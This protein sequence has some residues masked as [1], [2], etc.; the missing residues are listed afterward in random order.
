MLEFRD[1]AAR[2]GCRVPA[3]YQK[4]EG[5]SMST[6]V[7]P[8]SEDVQNNFSEIE[9]MRLHKLLRERKEQR[10]RNGLAFYKP[11]PKQLLFH[12]APFRYRYARVGNRFGKSTMG[13]AEDV[14][15]LLGERTFLPQGTSGRTVSIPQRPVKGVLICSDFD[16][17]TEIF[18]NQMGDEAARG[19][20]FQLLPEDRVTHVMKNHSGNVCKISVKGLYGTSILYIETVQSYKANTMSVESSDWDF[21]HVDE[22]IPEGMWKAM[23]R[24]LVDRGGSAWFVCTMLSEPWINDFFIPNMREELNGD[25]PFED[26]QKWTLTGSMYDNNFLDPANIKEYEDSL[27]EDEKACRIHGIPM[28]MSGTIYKE[29]NLQKHVYRQT[30]HGW[31]AKNDPP[32]EYSIRISV[33][34][35]PRTPTAVVFAA[36]APTGEVFFYDELFMAGTI[37]EISVQIKLRLHNRN[38]IY[39]LCDPLGFIESPIDG[40]SMCD[41]FAEH[42]IM[43]EKAP[44]DPQ[45]GILQVKECLKTEGL[46]HFSSDCRRMLY[47]FDHY[48]WSEKMPDRP[49]PVEN[50]TMEAMYRLVLTGLEYIEPDENTGTIIPYSSL[51]DARFSI[52]EPVRKPPKFDHS[53]R[54]K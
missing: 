23:S 52:P 45:N 4:M 6:V 43:L 35:H 21:I 19:K 38:V 47:E 46:F 1:A 32:Y 26:G 41:V 15:W 5:L 13:A 50:H 28:S 29:F 31:K 17:G 3:F 12:L 11:H 9:K 42:G 25:V 20:L 54:Y 7:L 49:N 14:S 37:D 34:P 2:S 33:D 53:V 8:S 24:G 48:R 27:T 51:K 44:K 39:G 16:K 40:R 10:R 36:T 22:P 18:T 30:P